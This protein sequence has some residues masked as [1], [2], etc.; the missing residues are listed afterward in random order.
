MQNK[1]SCR[2][3]VEIAKN[4]QL[5]KETRMGLIVGEEEENVRIDS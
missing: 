5:M 4:Q 2:T 1:E 3:V